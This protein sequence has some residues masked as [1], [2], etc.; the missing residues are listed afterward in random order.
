LKQREDAEIKNQ[1]LKDKALKAQQRQ[2][3]LSQASS[4]ITAGAGIFKDGIAKSGIVGVIFAAAAIASMVALFGSFKNDVNKTTKL[5]GGGRLKGNRHEDGGIPIGLGYEAEDGEWVVNR[6]VSE[7][8]NNFIEKLNAG[9]YNGIDL[10]K[11]MLQ[12]ERK[13]GALEISSIRSQ[14]NEKFNYNSMKT[15]FHEVVREQTGKLIEFDEKRGQYV[16]TADGYMKIQNY[17]NGSIK[18][19]KVKSI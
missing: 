2:E 10:E 15:A 13:A 18:I 6:N 16:S 9:K 11:A 3:A 12:F 17:Q 14:T 1:E 7:K 19:E 5:R 4:L 8:H